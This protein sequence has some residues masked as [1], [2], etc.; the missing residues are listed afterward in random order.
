VIEAVAAIAGTPRGLAEEGIS[1]RD[2][3]LDNLFRLDGVWAIGDFGPVKYPEGEPLTVHGRKVGAYDWACLAKNSDAP[4]RGIRRRGVLTPC[5]GGPPSWPAQVEHL[6]QL[7]AASGSRCAAI[8]YPKRN[9]PGVD[10]TLRSRRSW[11]R[12]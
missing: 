10:P 5:L 1:H 9:D 6:R 8:S 4:D 12:S 7:D 11:Y 3:K 2:L